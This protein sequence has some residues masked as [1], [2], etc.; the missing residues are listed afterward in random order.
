[1]KRNSLLSKKRINRI[2]EQ[3]YFR[4]SD[5]QI[6]DL[7]FGNRFAL[8]VCT[9]LVT[10]GIAL[11]NIP[12]LSIMLIVAILGFI[13]PYHPFDY[14]YNHFLAQRMDKPMLPKRSDQLKFACTLATIFIAT[15]IY[16][17]SHGFILLG[18]IV[19]AIMFSIAFTVSTTDFCLPSFIY[20][21]IF[22]SKKNGIAVYEPGST[23]S[24]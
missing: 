21:R 5:Q 4:M 11:A 2:R 1:M 8:I 6:S 14:I 18:Y 17:F 10:T 20:N 19:G 3:G 15:I 16:T 7:A 24:K 22:L 23:H 12:L 9:S 13:L